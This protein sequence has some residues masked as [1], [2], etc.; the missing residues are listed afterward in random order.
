MK[1]FKQ[2]ITEITIKLSGFKGTDNSE[3]VNKF[4]DEY[5]NTSKEHLMNKHAR[6]IGNAHVHVT[7]SKS[8][9][10]INDIQSHEQGSGSGTKALK[11]LTNL[12]DKHNVKLDL[13]AK[14]YGST[15]SGKLRKW[16]SRHG[17]V[18]DSGDKSD[19][20]RHPL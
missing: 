1:N 10:H 14:G 13:Y 5:H 8:G 12:A 16:Y 19:M 17:F 20:T 6:V 4:M 2:F 9:V 15:S 7:P 18:S 3:K 11:H